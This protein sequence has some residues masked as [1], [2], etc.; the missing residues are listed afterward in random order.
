M[1]YSEDAQ[2]RLGYVRSIAKN[3]DY[4]L[5][6]YGKSRRFREYDSVRLKDNISVKVPNSGGATIRNK[7][8]H[9]IVIHNNTMAYVVKCLSYDRFF[10]DDFDMGSLKFMTSK[11]QKIADVLSKEIGRSSSSG[12]NSKQQSAKDGQKTKAKQK[13]KA[14]DP[15]KDGVNDGADSTKDVK[16]YT[17]EQY[18]L[19]QKLFNIILLDFPPKKA[20]TWEKDYKKMLPFI[21]SNLSEIAPRKIDR[22]MRKVLIV[23]QK[24]GS[25]Y[26]SGFENG[27]VLAMKD[28]VRKSK[29]P[30]LEYDRLYVD[31][32]KSIQST[33][34]KIPHAVVTSGCSNGENGD[35]FLELLKKTD[36]K[37]YTHF[38]EG[39]NCGCSTLHLCA[40]H[41]IK[42]QH[43]FIESANK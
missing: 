36:S 39:N 22:V 24:H 31:V 7:H 6:N 28:I 34:L 15:S 21:Y 38:R 12:N 35:A 14:K 2:E 30:M 26:M 16:P 4:I 10:T 11:V 41:R 3:A 9:E 29:Y 25:G 8:G 37:V 43:S 33:R 40:K 20:K 13:G 32:V 23:F 18:S 5:Q 17:D 1:Q 27:V 19:A 42:I